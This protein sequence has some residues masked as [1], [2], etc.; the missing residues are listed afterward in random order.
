MCQCRDREDNDKN[1]EDKPKS[2]NLHHMRISEIK[3]LL[4]ANEKNSN[5][6]KNAKR[7]GGKWCVLK[8]SLWYSIAYEY[9]HTPINVS[10][11]FHFF[12]S[13]RAKNV[14]VFFLSKWPNVD[15]QIFVAC[16]PC[17]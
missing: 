4:A 15:Q 3:L 12:F 11:N 2:Y 14:C 9:T 5:V 7:S 1:K 6:Y 13:E 8:H 16:Y 17:Q 10:C